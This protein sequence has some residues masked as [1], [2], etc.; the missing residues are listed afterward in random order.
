MT[1]HDNPIDAGYQAIGALTLRRDQLTELVAQVGTDLEATKKSLIERIKAGE[2]SRNLIHDFV[3]VKLG[4]S[5]D[6]LM[7]RL[8]E[9][10]ELVA[11]HHG[12][13]ALVV[14]E[15]D[16]DRRPR[17]G[18]IFEGIPHRRPI[19]EEPTERRTITLMNLNGSN[20]II[21][22]K[23][24]SYVCLPADKL[25]VRHSLLLHNHRELEAFPVEEVAGPAKIV[26]EGPLSGFLLG[27]RMLELPNG[28]KKLLPAEILPVGMPEVVIGDEKVWQ[29][30][31]KH[32]LHHESGAIPSVFYEMRRQLGVLKLPEVMPI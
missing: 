16:L 31:E 6:A 10:N 23:Q 26:F 12:E 18:V 21:D 22:P 29:W 14:A 3:F 11:K 4:Q 2:R 28:E 24:T 19:G 25:L 1:D 8:T 30:M 5:N 7:R 32:N 9:L 20:L 15:E 27:A 13:L 17:R